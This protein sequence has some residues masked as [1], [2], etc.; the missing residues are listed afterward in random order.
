MARKEKFS[1]TSD[2]I[3]VEPEPENLHIKTPTAAAAIIL[4]KESSSIEEKVKFDQMNLKLPSA[5]K[6]KFHMWCLSNNISMSDFLLQKIR[7]A[8]DEENI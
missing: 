4:V 8:I 7:G 5:L 2:L 1:I 3:K 6:R